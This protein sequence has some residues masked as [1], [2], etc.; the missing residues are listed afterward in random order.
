[1]QARPGFGQWFLLRGGAALGGGEVGVR[2]DWAGGVGASAAAGCLA[3]G[4]PRGVTGPPR[5]VCA[6]MMG[7]K[8]MM[9]AAGPEAAGAGAC[10]G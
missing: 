4:I 9:P 5:G 2:G 8:G 1:M 10:D 6:G 7:T 3:G